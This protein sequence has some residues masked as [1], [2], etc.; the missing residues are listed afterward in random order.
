VSLAVA[1]TEYAMLY[2]TMAAAPWLVR[3]K[4]HI[5][6]EIL[7]RR[8]APGARR[9]LDRLILMLCLCVSLIVAALALLLMLEA[10]AR[11]EIEVR[12][13]DLPRWLLFAP[14]T[15]GFFLMATEFLRLLIRSDSV[16]AS[17][18]EQTES[19]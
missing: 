12:S 8:L 6:V 15:A 17:V 14:V 19:F 1:V 10:I 5:V 2:F 11:G 9:R 18:T 13:L 3:V 7:Y 16:F 4:G